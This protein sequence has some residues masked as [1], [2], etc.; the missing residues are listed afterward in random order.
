MLL[1]LIQN[2][3]ELLCLVS[4]DSLCDPLLHATVVFLEHF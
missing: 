2:H 1:V 4:L 3:I